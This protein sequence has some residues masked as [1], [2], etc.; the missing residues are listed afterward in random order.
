MRD[1]DIERED[2]VGQLLS[3][4][5]RLQHTLKRDRARM[6]DE[7]A[8]AA[9]L[10][11]RRGQYRLLHMLL[12]HEPMTTHQLAVRM[13]VS[14]PTIST[15]VHA[16]AEHGLINRERD[17]EDQRVVWISLSESGR[18]AVADER[19]RWRALFLH[20]FNQLSP[21]DQDAIARAI[22]ALERLVDTDRCEKEGS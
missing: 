9:I 13:E 3:L 8:L 2:I 7:D 1:T 17:A 11:E 12:D 6:M 21:A 18:R 20:R 15:M 14:A 22:P 4:L 16:L 19:R 5:P 10:S